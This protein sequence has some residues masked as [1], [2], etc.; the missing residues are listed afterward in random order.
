MAEVVRERL[1]GQPLVE[2]D[3]DSNPELKTRFGW[4]VPLLFDGER[5][6]CRHF[7]DPEAFGRWQ[8]QS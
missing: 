4:D 7:F 5:E 6:I 1:G 3:V 2:I 8:A